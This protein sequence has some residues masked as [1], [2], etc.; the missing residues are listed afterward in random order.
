MYLRVTRGRVDPGK[1]DEATRLVPAIQ[2]AIQQLPGCQHVQTGVDRATGKS[3]AISSFETLDQ[4]SRDRP[5][6]TI[7]PLLALGWQ[8]DGPEIYEITQ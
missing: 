8:G 3:I 2:A 6:D 7:A 1:S 4:F 5:S